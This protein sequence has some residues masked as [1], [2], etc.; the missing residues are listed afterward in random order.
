M[1]QTWILLATF[2]N[3]GRIPIAPGT[4]ASMVTAGI[5]YLLV[6]YLNIPLTGVLA[7]VTITVLGIPA[8]TAAEVHFGKTDPGECV[9]DE[10][11][12]QLLCLIFIPRLWTYYLAAFLIFRIID[13][14]KPFPIRR[15]EKIGRGLGIMLDDLLAGLYTLALIRLYMWLQPS[16]F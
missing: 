6:P 7:L 14:L 15:V 13:I 10:V 3:V 1:K 5:F 8:A 2:F 12:G 9:I 11:A 16:L 4:W